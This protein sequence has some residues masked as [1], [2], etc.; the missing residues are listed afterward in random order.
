MDKQ[1][2]LSLLREQLVEY[3]VTEKNIDKYIR[4]FER[5]FNTMTDDEINDQI[6]SYEGVDGIARSIIKLINKT[7]NN[8]Q[9]PISSNIEN[10]E[11]KD[12]NITTTTY[13]VMQLKDE[14]VTSNYSDNSGNDTETSTADDDFLVTGKKTSQ[15]FVPAK[16]PK[17]QTSD[18]KYKQTGKVNDL[19]QMTSSAHSINTLGKGSQPI[20]NEPPN[21]DFNE[22]DESYS[23]ETAIPDTAFYWII[24]IL[25]IP[26][27]AP[28]LLTVLLLFLAAFAVLA[29][30]VVALIGVLILIIIA[31]TGLALVGI[32]YGI[33]QIF[34]SLPIGLFEIGFGVII[35]GSA[36][37][38]GILVYNMAVRFL[39]FV[40]RYLFDFFV[41]SMNKIKDLL[42]LI[43]KECAKQ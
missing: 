37:L 18:I 43:K 10:N 29:I 9:I 1:T 41:F 40:I 4:Q 23:E 39:P 24:L 35:G 17:N 32:I 20:R 19:S 12:I 8:M 2:F 27:T 14:N 7:Q 28:L 30:T 31:G 42:K 3:N 15:G 26:I 13:P 6:Q 16:L 38:S 33:T 22:L 36:M 25:T 5:Y 34:T 21:I 11:S